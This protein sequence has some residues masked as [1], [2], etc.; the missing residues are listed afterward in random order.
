[1]CQRKENGDYSVYKLKRSVFPK[2]DADSQIFAGDMQYHRR[3]LDF[4]RYQNGVELHYL[5]QIYLELGIGVF[6]V[7]FR[8]FVWNINEIV[9][10]NQ[11]IPDLCFY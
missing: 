11:V 5:L 9:F 3:I 2:M 4:S 1:M 8:D 7:E 6:E 10:C